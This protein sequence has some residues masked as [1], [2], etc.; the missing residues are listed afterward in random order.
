[1]PLLFESGR[2]N[3]MPKKIESAL[4]ERA[5]RMVTEHQQE[6][7]SLTAACEAVARQVGVGKESVRRWVV[8][9][10]VDSGH[11]PGVTTSGD[12]QIK[13]LRAEDHRLRE[14]VAIL[15]AATQLSL[16]GPAS[17]SEILSRPLISARGCVRKL[18]LDRFVA[19][20]RGTEHQPWRVHRIR[21]RSVE[22]T[23]VVPDDRVSNR[24]FVP[25]YQ[26]R[27]SCPVEQFVQQRPAFSR[28]HP[29]HV[30]RR[31]AEDQRF[32]S[33]AVCPHEWLLVCAF[34]P[35]LRQQGR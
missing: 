6:Y 19:E 23:A 24:P 30:I 9:D 13:R 20:H 11:R 31:N 3:S 16:R 28:V 21:C 4:R 7:P 15:K 1:M 27:C 22:Y 10:Q 35:P 26:P 34:R 17:G 33:G 2:M 32:T 18:L 14:D 29:H 5:V 12:D 8:Q 25:V